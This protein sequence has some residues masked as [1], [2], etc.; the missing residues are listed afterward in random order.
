MDLAAIGP[1][2]KYILAALTLLLGIMIAFLARALITWLES[3]AGETETSWDDIVIAAIG[4]PA[5]VAII[6]FSLYFAL[7]WFSI[8]PESMMWILNPNYVTAFYIV[9]SA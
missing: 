3:K 5:Q 8:L 7:T 2:I 6:V 1:E 9:I 4:T